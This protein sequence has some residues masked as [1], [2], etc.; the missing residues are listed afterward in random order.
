VGDAGDQAL[1]VHEARGRGRGQDLR[2][3]TTSGAHL[4]TLLALQTTSTVPYAPINPW[5]EGG[6]TPSHAV[7]IVNPVIKG[8]PAD[9]STQRTSASAASATPSSSTLTKKGNAKVHADLVAT[10][11]DLLTVQVMDGE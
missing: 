11:D 6:R 10:R 8:M 7:S 1:A 2:S 3:K 9:Q 5:K 4:L